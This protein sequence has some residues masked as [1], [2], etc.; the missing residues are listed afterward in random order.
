M[1]ENQKEQVEN[2]DT[3]RFKRIVFFFLALPFCIIF[4]IGFFMYNWVK[5][6]F[7]LLLICVVGLI[8]FEFKK[9]QKTGS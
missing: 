8:F 3:K 2:V 4:W 5:I 1:N 9:G 6:A 7:V